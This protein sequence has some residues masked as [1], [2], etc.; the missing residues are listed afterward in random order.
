MLRFTLPVLMIA[1]V[2]ALVASIMSIG[3]LSTIGLWALSFI[4]GIMLLRQ[5]GLRTLETFVTR[6]ESGRAPMRDSWDGLCLM[7][8]G[9]LLIFPGIISDFIAVFLLIPFVRGVLYR[10]FE[11]H[12]DYR[13]DD[14]ALA[15]SRVTIIEGE[16]QDITDQNLSSSHGYN[17]AYEAD[18]NSV[19]RGHT[20]TPHDYR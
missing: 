4:F 2:V 9:L 3:F 5:Q 17:T 10:F 13:Y 12:G 16:Y 8:A 14:D 20:Q 11:Q 6:L 18:V 19:G 1:E 7:V 15:Q